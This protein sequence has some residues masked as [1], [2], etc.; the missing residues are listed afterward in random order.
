MIKIEI[1]LDANNSIQKIDEGIEKLQQNFL[2]TTF[3]K[4]INSA[5]DIGL[6]AVLPDLIENQIIDIKDAILENGFSEGM[7]EVINSGIDIGKSAIGIVTG[8]F[9][10]VSQIELAVK[11]GGI[12]DQV[13][14]LLDYSINIANKKNMIDNST[15]SIIRKGK[16]TIISS[17][18]NKIEET[19][20]NQIKAVEKIEKFTKK[21]KEAYG[22]KDFSKMEN[23]YKNIQ[24]YIEK[25]VPLEKIINDARTIENLHELIK[26]TSKDFNLSEE[27]ILLAQKLG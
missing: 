24:N 12:L 18:S 17:I 21:W 22:N 26:N 16:N 27:S 23:A 14:D 7:K 6:K 10:N 4:V 20:T 3:G 11:N 9:E 13:S 1:E 5:I 8:E 25:V 19:L 2:E 15:S